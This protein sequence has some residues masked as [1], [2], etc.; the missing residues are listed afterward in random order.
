MKLNVI[1]L[2]WK[3]GKFWLILIALSLILLFLGLIW[4]LEQIRSTATYGN[5]DVPGTESWVMKLSPGISDLA[6]RAVYGEFRIIPLI[7][8]FSLFLITIIASA[9]RNLMDFIPRILVQWSMF[10]VARIGVLRV[11]GICPLP[12]TAFGSFNFLNCQACEM[13]TGACPIGMLQWSLINLKFP[14]LVLGTVLLSGALIGRGVCGWLCPFGFLSDIFNRVSIKRYNFPAGLG[15]LKFFILLFIFSAILWPYPLF[16]SYLCASG[17]F[18]GLLPYYLTTGLPAFEQELS[19]GNLM[20]SLLGYHMF[21]GFVFA[22]VAIIV[23]GRWFCRYIC[24]L[25][26]FYGLLNRISP[27]RVI[28]DKQVCNDCRSCL[29]SCPMGIDLARGNFLDVSD[30]IKCGRCIIACKKN[31]RSFSI[32]PLLRRE[33]NES[34][35]PGTSGQQ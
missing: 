23:S 24:P 1:Q 12:R 33:R 34:Q 3:P 17:F 32:L 10:V 6:S 25:G 15:Y 2:V 28:I 8:I 22:M 27:F 9:Y 21:T 4:D 26:A 35:M 30:C 7:F 11:S 18:Y 14:F 19:Q 31:A 13:A 5:Y 16:C 29:S 20:T